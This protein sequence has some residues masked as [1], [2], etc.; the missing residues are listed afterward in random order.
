MPVWFQDALPI[1]PEIYLKF[2]AG[3]ELLLA[4]SFLTGFRMRWAALI[5]A[6]EMGGILL[7]NGIDPITF[8]DIAILGAAL[9]L[10]FVK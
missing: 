1:A 6:M 7:F 4:L 3:V 5:A 8:R 2:Q 9:S 10:F